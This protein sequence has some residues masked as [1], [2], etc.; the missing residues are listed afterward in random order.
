MQ[1]ETAVRKLFDQN[2]QQ[3][4]VQADQR[5][6]LR[7]LTQA[8]LAGRMSSSVF[9]APL[10][11]RPKVDRRRWRQVVKALQMLAARILASVRGSMAVQTL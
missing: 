4:A 11:Q 9:A 6:R 3:L 1:A 5:T 7:I 2:H 10:H 8:L